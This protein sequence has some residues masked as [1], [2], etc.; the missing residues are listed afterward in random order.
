MTDALE[1]LEA[2]LLGF[3]HDTIV[4]CLLALQ[5]VRQVCMQ[6]RLGVCEVMIHDVALPAFVIKPLVRHGAVFAKHSARDPLRK[7]VEDLCGRGCVQTHEV[8]LPVMPHHGV[9]PRFMVVADALELPCAQLH[10]LGHH[11]IVVFLIPLDLVSFI[12]IQG[13]LFLV[14]LLQCLPRIRVVVQHYLFLPAFVEEP[15]GHGCAI[16]IKQS[17]GYPFGKR[18]VHLPCRDFVQSQEVVFL[19]GMPCHR[20]SPGVVHQGL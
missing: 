6:R 20:M 2:Q 1:L 11:T 5:L 4:V 9:R 18:I 15:R 19:V 17:T 13:L 14:L 3:R 12:R 16:L 7:R 10:G 8:V